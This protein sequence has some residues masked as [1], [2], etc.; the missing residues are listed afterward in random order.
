MTIKELEKMYPYKKYNWIAYKISND[1]PK[2]YPDWSY[3]D[4]DI[5]VKHEIKEHSKVVDITD[6]VF[7]KNGKAKVSYQN[8]IYVYWKR[9]E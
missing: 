7:S 9:K 5:V 6:C 2:G 8:K 3:K 4:N 1:R